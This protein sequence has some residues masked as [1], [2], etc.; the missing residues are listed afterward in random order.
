MSDSNVLTGT[1]SVEGYSSIVDSTYAQVTGSH[2]AT[3]EGQNVLDPQAIS[4]GT[5]D[6]LDTTVLLTPSA[7]LVT[8]DAG[9]SAADSQMGRRQLA[10]RQ[11]TSWSFGAPLDAASLTIPLSGQTVALSGV[12]VGVVGASGSTQWETPV[13]LPGDELGVPVTPAQTIVGVE[14]AA[15]GRSISVDAPVIST[16]GG[17]IYHADGQLQDALVPPHWRF[18]GFDGAFAVF[19]DTRARPGLS[20]EAP[21]G[22]STEGAT[23]GAIGGPAWAPTRARLSSPHGVIVVRSGAAIPGWSATWRPSGTGATQ[24]LPV[25]LS[26]VVQAVSV[27]AGAGTLTWKYAAPGF[28]TALWLSG[29][30]L[31]ALGALGTTALLWR[32]RSRKPHH[33]ALVTA[34][35][36]VT[37]RIRST[38][39]WGDVAAWRPTRGAPSLVDATATGRGAE[40]SPE[41]SG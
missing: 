29:G 14:M 28:A 24:V 30:A 13:A 31:A 38:G 10:P 5:L 41:G 15:A 37:G 27:P 34:R 17:E 8:T 7:Y 1:P 40:P 2:Q 4:N 39:H 20:L 35:P 22:G 16:V 6:Q 23:I 36:F 25:R 18:Q 9:S 32:R 26:G 11:Q 21:P 12:R 33:G 19:D 3:G